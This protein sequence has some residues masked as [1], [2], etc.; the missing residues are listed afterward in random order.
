MFHKTR[1]ATCIN[2][3]LCSIRELF[4]SVIIGLVRE[5]PLQT[6]K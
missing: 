2:F 6:T 1:E 3:V 4:P 5:T